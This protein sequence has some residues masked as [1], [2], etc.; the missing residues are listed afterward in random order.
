MAKKIKCVRHVYESV[1]RDFSVRRDFPFTIRRMI[2]LKYSKLDIRF[3]C[4]IKNTGAM[5]LTQQ[6]STRKKRTFKTYALKNARFWRA[7]CSK[8][9]I[10]AGNVAFRDV[11][12]S[13]EKETP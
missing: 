9:Y 4:Q 1:L 11:C 6:V 10:N 3:P 12:T 5:S 13:K 8:I 2:L 7:S